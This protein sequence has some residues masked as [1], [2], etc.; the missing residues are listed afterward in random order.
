MSRISI[1]QKERSIIYE[2][3]VHA[4]INKRTANVWVSTLL[5]TP[6]LQ[7]D[8]VGLSGFD[9]EDVI[10]TGKID[11]SDIYHKIQSLDI[12]N[13]F[14]SGKY[15]NGFHKEMQIVIRVDLETYIVSVVI[16]ESDSLAINEL[17]NVFGL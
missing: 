1:E 2:Y 14:L 17:Q 13:V 3:S 8:F 12:D 16:S 5:E 4:I 11:S 6:N 7:I 15:K 9:K 10:I